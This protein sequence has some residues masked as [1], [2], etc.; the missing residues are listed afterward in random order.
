MLRRARRNRV[1]LLRAGERSHVLIADTEVPLVRFRAQCLQGEPAGTV[2]VKSGNAESPNTRTFPLH[3]ENIIDASGLVSVSIVPDQDTAITFTSEAQH[4][5]IMMTLLGAI[6]V[7]G[8]T[9]W[10]AWEFLG[11]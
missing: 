6:F 9:L 10:T 4:T 7:V 8:A 3:V 11:N 5:S 1:Q 2:E